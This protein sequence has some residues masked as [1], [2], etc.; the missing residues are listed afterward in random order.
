VD[1]VGVVPV[2]VPGFRRLHADD[3]DAVRRLAARGDA[4]GVRVDGGVAAVAAALDVAVVA[5]RG[6]DRVLGVHAAAR[7]AVDDLPGRLL[8][9][10]VLLVRAADGV[11][12]V[13]RE[14]AV[15]V[16]DVVERARAVA[17]LAVG[18]AAQAVQ[19][20]AV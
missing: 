2:D 5:G 15:L 8:R 19:R 20:R 3:D 13:A 4:A 1:L 18:L 17:G 10:V 16:K 7:A 12:G 9:A 14:D 6:D 11:A